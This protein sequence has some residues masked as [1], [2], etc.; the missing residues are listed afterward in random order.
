MDEIDRLVSA[1]ELIATVE[2]RIDCLRYAKKFTEQIRTILLM[3]EVLVASKRKL[4]DW[5]DAEEG[6]QDLTR[7]K[8]VEDL[9]REGNP[10]Y[11]FFCTGAIG[12]GEDLPME[13]DEWGQ[14]IPH[15]GVNIL[16]AWM[17]ENNYHKEEMV[18]V[19]FTPFCQ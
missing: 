8:F 10:W 13:D 11:Q 19:S 17:W 7:P 14:V 9:D 6:H 18:D 3:H 15:G 12:S 5:D 16:E 1:P 2:K 4:V